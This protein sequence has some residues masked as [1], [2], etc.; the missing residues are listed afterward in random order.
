MSDICI[1][2]C[3]YAHRSGHSNAYLYGFFNN[4]RIVLY[5]TL[6]KQV[7]ALPPLRRAIVLRHDCAHAMSR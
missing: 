4:K 6:I 7:P 3:G 5:D 2:V 1:W